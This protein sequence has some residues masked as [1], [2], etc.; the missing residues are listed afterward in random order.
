[1]ADAPDSGLPG[2]PVDQ[3]PQS[4]AE[5]TAIGAIGASA[6]PDN[7]LSFESAVRGQGGAVSSQSLAVSSSSLVSLPPPPSPKKGARAQVSGEGAIDAKKKADAKH[8]PGKPEPTIDWG[9]FNYLLENF[10]LIYGTDQVWDG[11]KRLTMK[12][13][14]M[15]HAHGA[16]MVRMWKASERRRTVMQEDMVFDPTETCDLTKCIN[17]YNGFAMEP[18]ETEQADVEVMLELLRHL[19]GNCSNEGVSIDQVMHWVLCWLAYP[20][21]RPGAKLKTALIFHGPQGTGKNLF[22]DAVRVIYGNYGVMVGQNE[23]EEKYNSWLSAK[24][25]VIGNEVVTRQELYHNKNKLKWVITEETIPI[26][27][28]H[29]DV[30]WERN[31]ANVAFLSNEQQPL[32]LEEGDRRYLVVY[33]PSAE[34]GNLYARVAA[35]LKCGGSA[36]LL[37]FLLQYDI[38][39]FGEHTKPL[40]T[41]AKADLIELSLRPS[42]RFMSEWVGGFLPLP[43]R[44][45]SAEQLYRAFRRWCDQAGE[46]FPPPRAQ[47]TRMAER[48]VFE[49]IERDADGKRKEPKLTY[50]VVQLKD[51][52]VKSGRTATRCWLPRGT[53][54]RDGVTEGAWAA[55]A[56]A[57]FEQPLRTFCRSHFEDSGP[58]PVTPDA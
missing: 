40:M 32:V 45:C 26:R 19:C 8:K 49:R 10:A 28:M 34:D 53:G 43:M 46:R 15:A 5:G 47:F 29:L 23:L 9:K 33:T 1:M 22:F 21:Q 39:D 38:G 24:L 58:A 51:E 6:P 31:H 37:H 48:W 54:P 16:D 41:A 55:E 44:V 7:V 17:L 30:R 50:K 42:E 13:G 35:F 14:N 20:L 11:V 18:D 36:K 2:A 27:A 25:M 57:D 52:S 12:I 56:V 4:P 3:P